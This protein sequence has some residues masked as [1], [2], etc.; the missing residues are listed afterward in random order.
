MSQMGKAKQ[1]D[2]Y[3]GSSE[4]VADA[5]LSMKAVVMQVALLIACSEATKEDHGEEGAEDCWGSARRSRAGRCYLRC[6]RDDELLS[7]GRFS[8]A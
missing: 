3:H 5:L 4:M 1:K 8:F 2:E 6:L 7:S